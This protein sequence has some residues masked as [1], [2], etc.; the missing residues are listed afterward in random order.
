MKVVYRI[1]VTEHRKRVI[2]MIMITI[3]KASFAPMLK[4]EDA[5]VRKKKKSALE[6]L[7]LTAVFPKV[8]DVTMKHRKHVIS[9]RSNPRLA[10]LAHL[11]LRRLLLGSTLVRTDC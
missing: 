3:P 1:P 8:T 7:M 5:P 10:D 9:D 11:S 6:S 4:M 2:P